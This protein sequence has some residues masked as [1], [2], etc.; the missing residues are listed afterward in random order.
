MAEL[1]LHVVV[2]GSRSKN[3]LQKHS[4]D[5]FLASR[6]RAPTTRPHELVAKIEEGCIEDLLF[7]WCYFTLGHMLKV[8]VKC[9]GIL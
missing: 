1:S 6:E 3:R 4:L 8:F 7:F 2:F 9:F 5:P